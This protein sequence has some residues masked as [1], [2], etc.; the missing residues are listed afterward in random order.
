MNITS[1][2]SISTHSCLSFSMHKTTANISIAI[3]FSPS[4]STSPPPLPLLL[5]LLL[6][7]LL[8]FPFSVPSSSSLSPPPPPLLASCPPR[9]CGKIYSLIFPTAEK[10]T[11]AHIT[12]DI[13]CSQKNTNS[14]LLPALK[15]ACIYTL[16]NLLKHCRNDL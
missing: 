10:W 7:P 2:F 11:N 4:Y 1:C 15:H 6:R 12:K 3:F 5:F 9:P 8:L 14:T 16:N 13:H